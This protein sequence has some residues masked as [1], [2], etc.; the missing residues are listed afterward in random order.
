MRKRTHRMQANNG[1]YRWYNDY[2]LPEHRGG[3]QITVKAEVVGPTAD[4]LEAT[5]I[6]EAAEEVDVTP[7]APFQYANSSAFSM[8]DGT[9]VINVV[10]VASGFQG[11]P[12]PRPRLL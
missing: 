12:H 6:R 1:L 7:L 2:R 8:P 11:E 10:L 5:V 9:P 4:I 3:G